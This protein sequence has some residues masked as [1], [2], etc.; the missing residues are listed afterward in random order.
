MNTSIFNVGDQVRHNQSNEIATITAVRKVVWWKY[1]GEV[2]A[3]TLD[4]GHSVKGTFGIELNG[5][6]Y[7]E[8]A[9]TM[10]EPKAKESRQAAILKNAQK[11]EATWRMIDRI[12]VRVK[13]T[14]CSSITNNTEDWKYVVSWY[15]GGKLIESEYGINIDQAASALDKLPEFVR[16]YRSR[17]ITDNPE[18]PK[19]S[20][21]MTDYTAEDFKKLQPKYEIHE[22]DADV[23]GHRYRSTVSGVGELQ[24]FV[25]DY[26]GNEA[27]A[28]YYIWDEWAQE[29]KANVRPLDFLRSILTEGKGWQRIN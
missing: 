4:F 2:N 20:S 10:I 8:E 15:D 16:L 26:A 29:V 13:R 28:L 21:W 11:S 7:R 23:M 22:L 5:G 24:V 17:E 27:H 9:L 12:Q 3:Y 18:R 25:S 6:E 19:A 14:A 1:E